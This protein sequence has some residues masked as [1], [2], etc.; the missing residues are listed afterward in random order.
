MKQHDKPCAG[1]PFARA[2]PSGK[3]GGSAPEVYI[4]QI[5][6]G[7]WL[8]CHSD[9]NYAGKLSRPNQVSQC[10]GSAIF[11]KNIGLDF[12][13]PDHILILRENNRV[14]KT[15]YHF[16]AHHTGMSLRRAAIEVATQ[17]T[18][19]VNEQTSKGKVMLIPKETNENG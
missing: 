1:C 6:A 7:F 16:Y 14:F 17:M 12:M 19:W 3:L 5:V 8:P 9:K 4:G 18:K 2:T 15:L 11:R 13:M 10:A